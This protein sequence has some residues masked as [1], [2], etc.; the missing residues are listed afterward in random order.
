M[1]RQEFLDT[2][3]GKV[4]PTSQHV[5]IAKRYLRQPLQ[6]T[7]TTEL[8]RLFVRE[9]RCPLPDGEILINPSID[10]GGVIH[11]VAENMTWTI[12][13]HEAVWN[14]LY[15]VELL[16]LNASPVEYTPSVKLFEGYGDQFQRSGSGSGHEFGEFKVLF[17]HSIRRSRICDERQSLS[18]ADLYLANLSIPRLHTDVEIALREAVRCFRAELFLAA[19]SHARQSM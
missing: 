12:A 17:P 3:R 2:I 10:L 1:N 8:L 11:Q 15:S 7:L 4:R 16:T 5:L 14:L 6:S 9:Q 18:N 13:F 19:P